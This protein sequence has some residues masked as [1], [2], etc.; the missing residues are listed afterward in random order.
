MNLRGV[1]LALCLAAPLVAQE[2]YEVQVY[3]SRLTPPGQ[4]MV[5][6]H[7]NF[8]VDGTRTA[9]GGVLPTTTTPCTR[10]WRSPAAS[11]TCSRPGCT[12]STA[13]S[14]GGA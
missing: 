8:T 13:C 7:S 1:L 10:R 4:T 9:E 3:G 14:R 12:C 6:L 2:N 11:T 5:E